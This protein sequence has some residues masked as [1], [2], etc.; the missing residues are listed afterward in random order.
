MKPYILIFI[1]ILSSC[2]SS[3]HLKKAIKKDD[4]I[5]QE[6]TITD[7]LRIETIDSIPYIVNDT[8]RYTYFKRFTDTL[9][10]TKYKYIQAPKTRQETRLEYKRDV[11]YN[12]QAARTERKRVV[13]QRRVNVVTQK[14]NKKI[15]NVKERTKRNVR[16]WISLILVALVVGFILGVIVKFNKNKVQIL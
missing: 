4:T 9:I 5:L 2:S 14:M 10:Q 6:R 13:S 1:I 8:I 15:Q 7:T 16:L 12:N 11:K 3:Y